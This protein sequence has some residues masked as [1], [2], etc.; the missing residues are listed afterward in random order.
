M[1]ITVY[2]IKKNGAYMYSSGMYKSDNYI[3]LWDTRELAELYLNSYYRENKHLFKIKAV[4]VDK[5]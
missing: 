3:L 2:A 5:V 4:K 1:I